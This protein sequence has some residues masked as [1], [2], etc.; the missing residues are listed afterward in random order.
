MKRLVL[1]F[2]LAAVL[3]GCS[4]KPS[5]P[6]VTA[7]SPDPVA[8]GAT[9][10]PSTTDV[11]P[12]DG[13]VFTEDASTGE[14]G[15]KP[16]ADG[17]L[18][19][20]FFE[21]DKSEL[22]P[23]QRDVVGVNADWIRRNPS[24]RVLVEGHCDERGTAQYNLALGER[25]ASAVK[26]FLVSLGIDGGRVQIVSYGKERPFNPGHDDTAWSQNRRGHFVILS[27]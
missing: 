4:S 19:D 16:T 18:K 22:S 21:L 5:S 1:P 11:G 6:P 25:R 27:R 10:A 14:K 9:A 7:A 8:T 13:K 26:D 24:V 2:A 3:A 15:R 23:E 17:Y 12:D 20:V